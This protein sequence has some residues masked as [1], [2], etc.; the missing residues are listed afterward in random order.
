MEFDDHPENYWAWKTSFQSVIDELT[1]SAREELDLLIKWLGPASKEQARRIRAIHSH[2][3]AAG[4]SMV[5]QRLEETYGT[6]EAVEHALLKRIEEF[7]RISNRDNVRLRELGDLLL[8]L[9]Y[10]KEGGY[11]PGLAYL[12]TSR[13]VKPILEKLPFSLQEKWISQ[14]SKYKNATMSP[15]H[16]SPSFHSLFVL[17]L[18]PETTLAL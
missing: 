13:G 7:P 5:W 12:D 6:P 10:A 9:E 16:L 17:K 4:L 3:S 14:G 15:I 11:L 1:L 18:K 8:E 2:N